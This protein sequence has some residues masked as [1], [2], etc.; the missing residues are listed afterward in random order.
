MT[1]NSA[2]YTN[3]VDATDRYMDVGD[4]IYA[5]TNT[6]NQ[7]RNAIDTIKTS[8]GTVRNL[9]VPLFDSAELNNPQRVRISGF[10][11]IQITDRSTNGSNDTLTMTFLR[12]CD[13]AGN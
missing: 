4:Y 6:S 1:P 7:T 9:I 3:P 11:L 10:A 13:S 5:F 2:N 12:L 8:G